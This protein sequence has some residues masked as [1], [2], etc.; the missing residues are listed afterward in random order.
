MK[1]Y[2]TTDD[3]ENLPKTIA[4]AIALKQAPYKFEQLGKHKTLGMLFFNSSLRTRLSTQKAAMQL[5]M[6]VMVMNFSGEAWSLEFE[7][8]SV[9]N[10]STS[11]HIREAAAVISQYC[12]IIAVRAFPTLTDKQKD[13]NEYVLKSFQK[14]A[15]VP[16]INM[17]SATGHPLQALTDAITITEQRTREKPKVVLSWAPHP[18]ALPH[19]V[20]N[21]FTS[22][23]QKMDADFVITHPEGYELNPEVTGDTPII[24]NQDEAL[25]DADFVYVKSW[26]S[27]R[28]YGKVLHTDPNWRITADKMALTNNGK[29]MHCLPVRR[30]IIVDDA[31]LDSPQSIVIPQANNRTFAAQ[32]VL[33]QILESI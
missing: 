32:V 5:G 29:F 2:L 10:G 19:A 31:V 1:H 14:Y 15:S 8:G 9:M 24:Y 18:K 4:D 13:E 12:D 28:D 33:K 26:S 20:A 7:D 25:K 30:N 3:I 11:E 27:Y 22:I 23:M 21:S 17:E 16:I 6:Q